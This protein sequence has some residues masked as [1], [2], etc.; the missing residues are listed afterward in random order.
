MKT[1]VAAV[2]FMLSVSAAIGQTAADIE[3]KYGKPITTYAVSD[4][5]WMTPEYTVDAQ[6]CRMRLFPKRISADTNYLLK[7][8]PFDEF[9]KVVDQ[10]VP[11]NAR[12][13]KKEPFGN[14][15]TGGGVEWAIF[16]YQKVTITYSASFDVDP[17]SWQKRKPFVFSLE[18]S[19]FDTKPTD[20]AA[21]LDDFFRYRAYSFEIVTITW[22]D[23]KC[24]G[25]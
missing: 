15:A 20:L 8:L 12:G 23:R 14:G 11:V 1:I 6:V 10:L 7:Q 18:G 24:A 4:H 17:N 9:K 25:K 2:V 3:K 22:N 13:K 19:S 16:E 5:V 21:P